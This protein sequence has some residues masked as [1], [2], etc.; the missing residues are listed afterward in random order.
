MSIL[1]YTDLNKIDRLFQYT[2]FHVGLYGALTFGT[3]TLLQFGDKNGAP[4]STVLMFGV[5]AILAWVLAGFSGGVIL[6]T[7]VGH[8]GGLQRFRQKRTGP[9][10]CGWFSGA[11]WECIEHCSFWLGVVSALLAL[12]ARLYSLQI[13]PFSCLV[14]GG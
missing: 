5:M 9:L 13:T 6:G 4:T 7:L 2:K 1:G 11:T 3:A 14:Q 10:K 8:C 12:C